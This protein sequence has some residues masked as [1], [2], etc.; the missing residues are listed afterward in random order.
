MFDHE[1][2]AGGCG[3]GKLPADVLAALAPLAPFLAAAGVELP[4]EMESAVPQICLGD[5]VGCW[6]IRWRRI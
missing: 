2:A 4:R 3:K 5:R 1:A 6:R